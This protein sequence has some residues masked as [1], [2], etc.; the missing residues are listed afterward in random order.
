MGPIAVAEHLIPFL[1]GHPV[2][3]TN[4]INPMTAVSAAPW[5]SAL[6]LLISYG[7]IKMLGV[8]GLTKST[9][10][11]MLNA[12]YLKKKLETHFK[13][14]YKGRKGHVAHEMIIDCRNFKA[15][16]HISV[17]DIAKRLIDYGFHAPTVSFP[18]AGT[19]MIEPTETETIAT[20]D[21]FCDTVKKIVSEIE[22]DPEMVKK[23]PY[24]TPVRRLD[25]VLAARQP[26]LRWEKGSEPLVPSAGQPQKEN[27]SKNT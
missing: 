4:S 7:Y 25:E 20:L 22:T 21:E 24:T 8:E 18:V 1:P 23:S 19:L 13:V 27:I 2:V 26:F 9:Q 12:N 3:E 15:E 10:I 17:E 5:G 11:A 6:I 14:L 16:A